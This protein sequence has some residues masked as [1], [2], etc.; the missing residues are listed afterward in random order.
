MSARSTA[1]E[2][3]RQT[4]LAPLRDFAADI[5][6]Y[7]ERGWIK[8]ALLLFFGSIIEGF[9]I[10]LLVPLLSVVIDSAPAGGWLGEFTAA[11][12]SLAPADSRLG[13]IL[14]LLGLFALVF[15]FRAWLI[16]TRD[17]AI[18]RLQTGFIE[19]HR[20][21]LVRMLAASRWDVLARLRHGRV[22]HVLGS[23]LDQCANAAY[24]LLH[25]VVAIAILGG[26]LA[27]AF[28]FSPA[29]A[30]MIL[31]LLGAGALAL[32]PMLRRSQELGSGVNVSNRGVV[33]ATTEFLG[34]LKLAISQNL[35]RSFLSEY[36]EAL[37]RGSERRVE[38][39]RQ[40]SSAQLALAGVAAAVA[41]LTVLLGVGVLNLAPAAAI[42]FL[43]ILGRM[44]GPAAQ[45]Q[46]G[47]QQI[48]HTLPAYAELKQLQSEL[49]GARRH[50]LPSASGTAAPLEDAPIRIENASYSHAGSA[51]A[52]I[53]DVSLTI[54][55]GE[56]IGLTGPSGAGKTTLA[57]LVIGLYPPQRGR[58]LVGDRP[59]EGAVLA[60]WREAVSY[61]SQEPFLFHDSIRRNLLWARPE[62]PE[63]ALWEA[64]ELAGA[65]A[66]VQRL[67][68]GLD[69]VVGERGTLLSGGERQR[70]ALSRALIRKPSLLLLD[71]ATSAIDLAGEREILERLVALPTP[72]TMLIIAH[73]AESLAFCDRVIEVRGGRIGQSPDRRSFF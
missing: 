19:E 39:A 45:V 36:R 31:L 26:Q 23:D 4:L 7:T 10:L 63:D 60:A 17:V 56:F 24:L 5:L 34:G 28:L 59:L 50:E 70:I 72:P 68:G 1:P 8:I 43:F 6:A 49:E 52:G 18:A 62:A 42:A 69:S 37:H 66:L 15:A 3:P 48:F 47:A 64:L 20:L 29:L 2:V 21:R 55:P 61:V 40:R 35:Q 57:D 14:F 65:A 33:V 51:E 44:N 67:E 54:Q 32:R 38:F 11:A 46:N 25:G 71:E 22:T 73:R 9:G 58:V 41:G 53:F 12:V 13:R 16:M 30:A 27:L